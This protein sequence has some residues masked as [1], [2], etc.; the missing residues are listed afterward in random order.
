MAEALSPLFSREH[1]NPKTNM[2]WENIQFISSLCKHKC[3]A[4]SSWEH[5]ISSLDQLEYLLCQN[6]IINP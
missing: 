6:C 4:A 1:N 5:Q 2:K 3:V